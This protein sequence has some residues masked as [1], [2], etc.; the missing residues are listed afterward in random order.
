[1]RYI[2]RYEINEDNR[3]NIRYLTSDQIRFLDYATCES[4]STWSYNDKT[5]S[6][7]IDGVFNMQGRKIKKIPVKIGIVIG[8]F[9]CNYGELISLENCPDEVHGSFYCGFN[10][11]KTLKGCPKKVTDKFSC[12][13][14][15]LVTLNGIPTECKEYYL[16]H[17][18][19]ES[20]E[21][22]GFDKRDPENI[23]EGFACMQ[24]LLINLKGCPKKIN[25][26]NCFG[27]LID[28]L[29]DG[30]IEVNDFLCGNNR[31]KTLDGI[32]V[33][34]GEFSCVKNPLVSIEAYNSYYT[35][36]KFS[37]FNGDEGSVFW[38][39][40]DFW[41]KSED[42]L[43]IFMDRPDLFGYLME[44]PENLANFFKN[45]ITEFSKVAYGLKPEVKLG[46]MKKLGID[47]RTV[48][49]IKK[50]NEFGLF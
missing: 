33:I 2:K 5:K 44:D 23:C 26:L 4:A 6:V 47:Q 32:P 35:I 49:A 11:L 50:S 21:S 17:N 10:H 27:N 15:Q 34:K 3:E 24:N 20:L 38:N 16:Q 37:S 41:N 42:Y 36:F 19:L 13:N 1:M 45:N 12:N 30:P 22:G 14:N 8:D 7:D 9:L 25:T 39:T 48:D 31:L 28:T 18:L 29:I 43:K 40:S 46:V